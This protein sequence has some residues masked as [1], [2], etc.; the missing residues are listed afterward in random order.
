M[1]EG[2]RE[3][4]QARARLLGANVQTAVGKSTDLLVCGENVGA[5]KLEKAS[6]LGVTIISEADYHRLIGGAPRGDGGS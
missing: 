1:M 2:S 4:M 3:Q 6:R 5:T